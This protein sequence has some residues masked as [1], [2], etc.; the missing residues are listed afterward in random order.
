MKI[1][2]FISSLFFIQFT[3]N[4]HCSV[5]FFFILFLLN[6]LKPGPDFSYN[7]NLIHTIHL[8]QDIHRY[9]LQG[10]KKLQITKIYFSLQDRRNK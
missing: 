3:S 6:K 1:Q 2:N 8:I 5:R 4:F 7:N 9:H 10:D